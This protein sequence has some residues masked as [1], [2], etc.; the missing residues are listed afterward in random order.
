MK[1]PTTLTNAVRLIL[2]MFSSIALLP[3][4]ALAQ[5]T[6]SAVPITEEV[7]VTGSR[8]ARNE[9]SGPSPV[10]TIDAGEI[11]S[12]GYVSI[13]DLLDDLPQNTGGSLTQQSTHGFT[14]AASGIDIRGVGMGRSLVLVNGHRLPMYP[15]AAGGT[16]NFVDTANLP[17]GA[18]E[19]VEILTGGASAIYGSDAMGGVINIILKDE[20]DGVSLSART[21]ATDGGGR[22]S[23]QLSLTA[24]TSNENSSALFF[25]E[26][27]KRDG[28][29]AP[30]RDYMGIGTDLAF[31]HF[32]SSYSSYGASLRGP[33]G[34]TAQVSPAEPECNAR[35]LQWWD[36]GNSNVNGICGFDR[37]S[38]RDLLPE[39]ERISSMARFKKDLTENI[40]FRTDFSYTRSEVLSNIEPMPIGEGDYSW[41]L[42][43]TAD[44]V[45][46]TSGAGHAQVFTG[47]DTAFGGDFTGLDDGDYWYA[48]RGIEYG[49]RVNNITTQNLGINIGLE[50]TLT[51]NLDFDTNWT[52]SKLNV[53][54]LNRGYATVS[55]FFDYIAGNIDGN[56][57]GNSLLSIIPTD[58]VD[59][60]Q[61]TPWEQADTSLTGF[62]FNLNGELNSFA[63]SGGNIKWA[64]GI[65]VFRTWFASDTDEPSKKLE[66]LT[67]GGASGAGKRDWKSVYGEAL[68]PV[69]KNVDITLAARYDEYSDFG[70]SAVPSISVEYRPIE[71]LLIRGQFAQTFR[72]PDMQR[73]YGDPSYGSLQVTDPQGCQNAGGTPGPDSPISACN[74]EHYID[75]ITGPNPDLDAEQGESWSVGAVYG[76]DL[77][78]GWNVSAD[79][80]NIRLEDLVNELD[81]QTILSD[82]DTWGHLITRDQ[83]GFAES[84]TATAQNVSFQETQGID[85]AL[86]YAIDAARLGTFSARLNS[87][88]LLSWETQ[89][90]VN[91]DVEDKIEE[92]NIPEWRHV[93]RLGWDYNDLSLALVLNYISKMNGAFK[94]DMIDWGYAE[95]LESLQIDAHTTMNLSASYQLLPSTRIMVGINNLTDEGPNQDPT[96][97]GW[98]HYPREYYDAVGREFFANVE[99]NF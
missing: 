94:K 32:F 33:N 58:M 27:E 9:F 68:L 60:T 56:S 62:D 51:D 66:V 64:A 91:S 4:T 17:L 5:Q 86:N 20:Y 25:V 79:L 36:Y 7:F 92:T 53:D 80:W 15:K 37:T 19:R 43:T 93:A 11:A 6:E 40:R 18:V 28:L 41:A 99:L 72:A 65:E 59:A 89:F 70:S 88:Y 31:D 8:I 50:G 82:Y 22:D 87:A 39:Q 29:M 48:H 2:L 46:L 3:A 54:T 49:N 84:V 97:Y 73:V 24:G 77:G 95:D 21:S 69:M 38:M 23:N 76:F 90:D 96:D 44:T 47:V 74:G 13:Q 83:N 10:V 61:Y 30:Q 98:P 14:P 55:G 42:D 26:Y 81:A 45:T 67:T 12:G 63:L 71:D 85:F 52:Y 75:T 35:G 34:S 57:N 1:E 78:G 16:D